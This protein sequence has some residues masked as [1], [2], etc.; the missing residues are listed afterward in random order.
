MSEVD[1]KLSTLREF[2]ARLDA[3]NADASGTPLDLSLVTGITL[4]SNRL[5]EID[6]AV[7]SKFVSLTVLDLSSNLV[8]GPTALTS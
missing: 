3:A 8:G 5:K 7:M 6:R 4:H 1:S 2:L